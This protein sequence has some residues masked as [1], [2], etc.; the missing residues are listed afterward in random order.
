MWK[1]QDD[2]L[3]L[4]DENRIFSLEYPLLCPLCHQPSIHLYL[5]RFGDSS[6]GSA[7]VW[8]SHCKKY[9]HAQYRIPINWFNVDFIDED[10]LTSNPAYLDTYATNIDH[11]MNQLIT[12]KNSNV[13]P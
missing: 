13:S 4:L 11:H 5:H 9:I 10:L 6:S 7:W 3:Y 1:E 8:C 12:K 2:L